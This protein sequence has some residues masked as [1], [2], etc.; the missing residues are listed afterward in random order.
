MRET[1]PLPA[2]H[3]SFAFE[4]DCRIAPCGLQILIAFLL[5]D[6]ARTAEAKDI[7][8]GKEKRSRFALVGIGEV[9]RTLAP[10]SGQRLYP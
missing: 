8:P 1:R 5:V 7:A 2:S 4:A 3:A 6:V 10:L 9:G